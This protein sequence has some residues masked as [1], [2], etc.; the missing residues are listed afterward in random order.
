MYELRDR[1]KNAIETL[2]SQTT[3]NDSLNIITLLHDTF[4]IILDRNQELSEA[5]DKLD[6]LSVDLVRRDTYR[7]ALLRIEELEKEIQ[8]LKQN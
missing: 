8:L 1:I 2:K 3:S 4:D 7:A 5:L 6:M